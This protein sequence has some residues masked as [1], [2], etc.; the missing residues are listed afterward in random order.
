MCELLSCIHT[1]ADQGMSL[2]KQV[3]QFFIFFSVSVIRLM[4][5]HGIIDLLKAL[6]VISYIVLQNAKSVF[7]HVCIKIL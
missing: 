7:L 4:F 1:F 6:H 2:K 3:C 5:M